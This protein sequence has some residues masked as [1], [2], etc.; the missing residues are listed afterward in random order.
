MP[1]LDMSRIV[2]VFV[3]LAYGFDA[4]RWNQRCKNGQLLGVNEPFPY[5]YHRA[6]EYDCRI[7]YSTDKVENLIEKLFRLGIRFFSKFDFVHAWR[8][9]NSMYEADVVWT[10]TESQSLAILLLFLIMQPK[11]RPKLIAQTIW[12]FDRWPKFS[13]LHRWMFKKLLSRA[14]VLTVLSPENLKFVR[15]LLPHVRSELVFF[16]IRA[17]EKIEPRFKAFRYPTR[18]VSLGNDEHRDWVT[19]IDAVRNLESYELRVAS[20]KVGSKLVAGA[21][22]VKIVKPKSNSELLGLYEWA[23]LVI[24]AMKPNIHA[25]GITVLQEAVLRGAPVICSDVG[26]LRAYFSETLIKYVPPQDTEAIRRAI[27][28]LAEDEEGRSARVERAQARMGPEGLSSHAYIK[29][30]VELSKELLLSS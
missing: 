17:E 8:N 25:S 9:R 7:V 29:R 21:K 19:L 22:N 13:A 20:Q 11:R 5:G 12:L 14:D 28:E 30:H 10:H 26:G 16:G 4:E 24:L 2:N 15:E 3:H 1:A 6:E 23:D 18:L 27:R